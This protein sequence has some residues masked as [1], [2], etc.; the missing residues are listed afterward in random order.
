MTLTKTRPTP[1]EPQSVSKQWVGRSNLRDDIVGGG[2]AVAFAL[3]VIG[4]TFTFM[5]QR[6]IFERLAV[7]RVEALVAAQE[8]RVEG[9]VESGI[10]DA[11]LLATRGVIINVLASVNGIP[12]DSEAATIQDVVARVADVS[13]DVIWMRV[14]TPDLH[15]VATAGTGAIDVGEAYLLQAFNGP[16]AGR[17]VVSS[18]G[19]RVHLVATPIISGDSLVGVAIIGQSTADLDF[20][21]SDYTGLGNTGETIIAQPWPGGG[22]RFITPI[23]FDVN[24]ALRRT[25]DGTAR[26]V[27]V[28]SAMAD[29]VGVSTSSVDY[30]GAEVVSASRVVE[31]TNWAVV[32]KIDRAEAMEPLSDFL[33][34]GLLTL[35]IGSL[36]AGFFAWLIAHQIRK[37]ILEMKDAA[38][39][40]ASGDREVMVPNGRADEIGELASAFNTMTTELNQ[41]TGSLEVQVANR[42]AEL[43][44]RN[45]ELRTLMAA[46]ETF[47]AAVSHE[48]RG[49]LTAMMGFLD[50]IGDGSLVPEDERPQILEM[51]I[52]QADEVLVLIEDLL[53]AARVESGTLKVA[54]VRVNLEAQIRQVME[55][56]SESSGDMIVLETEPTFAQGDPSR[57]R[58]IIRNLVSNA[59]RYGGSTIK[60]TTEQRDDRVAVLISDNGEGVAAEDRSL[61]FDAYGQAEG[62]KKI[63]ASVGIGLHV[64]RQLSELMGGTLTYDYMDGWSV[65]TL[66]LPVFE[67]D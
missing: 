32:A 17:V 31:I 22:A 11:E 28:I 30:R 21:T 13:Q 58:Q 24:A 5:W 37:P 47:L 60:M 4:F 9:F 29:T 39:A 55:G 6:N 38:I 34:F 40:V 52:Q 3:L 23:R 7:D 49:P 1:V 67:G 20:L 46:K 51:A 61:I 54:S 53:A 48:V 43:Q 62:P 50:L 64:S 45:E 33:R 16:T 35:L 18:N 66:E 27:P 14:F 26:N 25:V 41:L 63:E 57:A 8:V 42:T 12:T 65:F 36:L 19:E 15:L 59:V 56:L 2:F 10:D 44:T